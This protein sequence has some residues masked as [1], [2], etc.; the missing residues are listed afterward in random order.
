MAARED[1]LAD[2]VAGRAVCLIALIWL[3]DGLCTR[4]TVHQVPLWWD[5]LCAEAHTHSNSA[6]V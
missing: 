6:R 5:L 4:S 1:V 3:A 2:E